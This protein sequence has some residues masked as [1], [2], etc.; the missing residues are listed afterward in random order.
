MVVNT[1]NNHATSR[2]L[3]HLYHLIHTIPELLQPEEGIV[4]DTVVEYL[5]PFARC[6]KEAGV[7]TFLEEECPSELKEEWG[8]SWDEIRC[9]LT[10]LKELNRRMDIE[11]FPW[12]AAGLKAMREHAR[13]K[14][15][16]SACDRMV[17]Y[18]HNIE[19][20]FETHC[21]TPDN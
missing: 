19:G 8:E 21:L 11:S 9:G 5:S 15:W 2:K 1:K 20:W 6:L 12:N 13:E 18:V 16:D 7:V 14:K 10:D 3:A 17:C 4:N